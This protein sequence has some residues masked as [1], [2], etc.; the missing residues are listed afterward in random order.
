MKYILSFS[1]YLNHCF[2]IDLEASY[3]DVR[4]TC[5]TTMSLVWLWSIL[6]KPVLGG[7]LASTWPWFAAFIAMSLVLRFS[8]HKAAHGVIVIAQWLLLAGFILLF[9][10]ELGGAPSSPG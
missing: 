3:F 8:D 1:Q 7:E 6:L 5:F 9:R 10:M 4:R 2:V